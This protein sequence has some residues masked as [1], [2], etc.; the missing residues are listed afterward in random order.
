[1]GGGEEGAVGGG[2]EEMKRVSGARGGASLGPAAWYAREAR[3]VDS[4]SPKLLGKLGDEYDRRYGLKDE[5]LARISAINYENARRNPRAQ[6]RTWYMNEEHA[7]GCDSFNAV[8]GGGREGTGGRPG[9]EG[10]AAGVRASRAGAQKR[11][12]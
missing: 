7:R 9:S 2:G 8:I 6:T 1:G 5:H 3:G 12:G 11:S 10:A 4:P